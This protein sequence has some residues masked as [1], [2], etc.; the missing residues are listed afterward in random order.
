MPTTDPFVNAEQPTVFQ[1]LLEPVEDFVKEQNHRLPKHRN[2]KY[3]Y[4]DF[5]RLMIDYFV[6]GT[7]S[8]KL[9]IQVRLN[10]GLL[11]PELG[12]HPVPSYSTCQDAFERFPPGLFQAVFQHLLSSLSFKAVPKVASSGTALN[13]RLDNRCWNTA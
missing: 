10:D 9:L 13:D 5:F 12:L 6:S 1:K 8:L 7:S 3:A 4:E 11:P 2:Q